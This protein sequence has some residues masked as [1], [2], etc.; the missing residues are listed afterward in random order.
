[1]QKLRLRQRGNYLLYLIL[2]YQMDTWLD[3]QME[4]IYQRLMAGFLM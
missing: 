1:M 3:I 4:V 2:G